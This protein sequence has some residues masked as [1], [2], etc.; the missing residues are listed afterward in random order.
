M[1][2]ELLARVCEAREKAYSTFGE[3]DGDVMTPLIN[4]AFMG[5]PRWPSLR[6]GWRIIRRQA[7]TLVVSDGLSDPFDDEEAPTIGF[8][9]EFIIETDEPIDGN[10]AAS[11]P[12]QVVTAVSQFAADHGG[13]RQLLEQYGALSSEFPVSGLSEEQE[14]RWVNESGRVGVLLGVPAKTLPSTLATP[15]GEVV[16]VTVKPLLLEELGYILENGAQGR[17]ELTNRL[18]ASP[19]GHVARL[20]RASVV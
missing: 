15:A 12:F 5:G 8:G 6:Q 11:W 13:L 18:S 1:H 7:H 19:E 3:L 4:P 17:T 2:D 10:I 20:A 14:A 16:L 9:L